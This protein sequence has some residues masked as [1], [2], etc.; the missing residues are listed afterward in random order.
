MH[1]KT[2]LSYRHKMMG[3][4][5]TSAPNLVWHRGQRTIR[6]SGSPKLIYLYIDIEYGFHYLYFPGGIMLPRPPLPHGT[7]LF[8]PGEESPLHACKHFFAAASL[9]GIGD[10]I[11]DA[12]HLHLLQPHGKT[13]PDFQKCR[14]HIFH[15][16]CLEKCAICT[17]LCTHFHCKVVSRLRCAH[18]F[19]RYNSGSK[20]C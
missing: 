14:A 3:S 4:N 17:S 2:Y 8:L 19:F 15:E 10:E 6:Y 16:R 1:V 9:C 5:H 12:V 18:D 7:E 13:K 11:V 20:S